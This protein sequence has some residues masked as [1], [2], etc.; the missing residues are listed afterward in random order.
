MFKGLLLAALMLFSSFKT[1]KPAYRIFNAEGKQ[2][3][4]KDV[5]KEALKSDV[6]YF[7]ELHNN[8]I[9]HWLQIELTRSLYEA[10]PAELALGAEMFER[11]DQVLL[12]EYTRGLISTASFEGQA[13]LWKNYKTDYKPLVEFARENGLHFVASNVPRR[14]ASIVNSHGF[15]GLDTLTDEARR[16]IAPLPVP[17]DSTIPSYAAMMEMGG[18]PGKG[19]SNFPKAQAIKDATMAH[20]LLESMKDNNLM[21]H[22]HGAYHSKNKEGIVWYVNQYRP[23]LKQITITTVEQDSL[24]NLAEEYL[25]E[26]DFIIVVPSTMTKTY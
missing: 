5:V 19:S 11:D 24:E 26:A 9:S 1:D 22:F 8:P 13:R 2:V 6:V 3:Q 16:W 10:R 4:Y 14:Y 23:G 12:D 15:E 25:N 17:F 21:L 7:G 20:F 18:M